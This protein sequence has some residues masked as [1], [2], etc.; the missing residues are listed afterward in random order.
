MF[1]SSS[2]TTFLEP[3]RMSHFARRSDGKRIGVVRLRMLMAIR[4]QI[5]R[6][7]VLRFSY[8]LP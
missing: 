6:E 3:E 7:I 5:V 1:D 4:M 8:T 2:G